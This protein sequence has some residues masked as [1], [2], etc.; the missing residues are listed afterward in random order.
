MVNPNS[1]IFLLD[2]DELKGAFNRLEVSKET[3]N[4]AYN[5]A[6]NL[7]EKLKGNKDKLEEF[8]N[9]YLQEMGE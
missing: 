3:Y 1:E 6:N 9:K 4:M 5:E 7:M 8:T 2:E